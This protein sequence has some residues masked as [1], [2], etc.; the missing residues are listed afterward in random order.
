LKIA[1]ADQG[2]ASI[3][4][5]LLDPRQTHETRT[6]TV[7]VPPQ[8]PPVFSQ[9]I[10]LMDR[11]GQ[12]RRGGFP[13]RLIGG[14]IGNEDQAH[15]TRK[16]SRSAGASRFAFRRKGRPGSSIGM[17]YQDTDCS[18]SWS[19]A[20]SPR[21]RRGLGAVR[22]MQVR[23][24]LADSGHCSVTGSMRALAADVKDLHLGLAV[25]ERLRPYPSGSCG[26]GRAEQRRSRHHEPASAG[27]ASRTGTFCRA[28][29]RGLSWLHS[30]GRYGPFLVDKYWRYGGTPAK[31]GA[32]RHALQPCCNVHA[33]AE[34]VVGL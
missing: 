34:D 1:V 26:G 21:R 27:R 16:L 19:T 32:G 25:R 33:V 13:P 14:V 5:V 10:I 8:L 23:P 30:Q 22:A 31:H 20:A 24:A 7:R 18:L 3:S 6:K 28:E 11:M 12:W 15:Q 2:V 4:F 29:L 9:A 17:M